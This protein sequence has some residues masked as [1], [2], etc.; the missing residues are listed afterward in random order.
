MKTF[1]KITL[2]AALAFISVSCADLEMP[3]DGRASYKDI[4]GHY[5]RTVIYANS[6]M[7]YV[8]QPGLSIDSSPLASLCDEAQD[9]ADYADGNI[10]N[11]YNG[12]TSPLYNPAGDCWSHYYA[13]IRRCNNFLL[14]I[15]DPEYC[16]PDFRE[17]EKLGWIAMVRVARAYYYLQL[18]K[19][20]GPV[21]L[22]TIPY[23]TGHDYT[24]DRRASFEEVADFIISEC[25]RALATP[26]P[27]GIFG[28]R[29][30]INDSD[31]GKLTR[32]FAYAIMS[33]TALFAASPLFNNGGASKYTWE[34]ATSIT[35]E[36]LD[37]CLNH[38]YELYTSKPSSSVAFGPYDYYCFTQSDPSRSVDKETIYESTAR[39]QVWM[40]CGLP[41]T[42]GM[43]KAGAC[44]S[45][46]LVD[47][48][49]TTDGQPVLDLEQPYLDDDHLKPNYN[50]DNTVY[51][52]ADPYANRDPRFYGSIY[53]NNAPR[54]LD[55]KTDVV[56]TYAGG[57][58]GISSDVNE[59]RYTRTGYYMRKFNNSRSGI[60]IE[61]DG[62]IAVYR[63][64]E[65][66]LNFA[67]AANHSAGPDVLV[68]SSVK[69]Q[70]LSARG[71]IDLI[72]ARV[73]MPALPKGLT[74]EQF[75]L[76]CRNERRVELA[77]EEKRFFDVRRWKILDRTDAFVTGMKIEPSYT[78]GY[79]YTRVKLMERKTSS[80]KYLL[81]PINQDD[82][83]KMQDYTGTAWQNPGW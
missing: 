28:F 78:G 12:M 8:Q 79:T 19:R 16:S 22:L 41:T 37:Q 52:P 57:N 27:D 49:E 45:Q 82:V 33:E 51:K 65:L 80:D 14:Y 81:F 67:E 62:F 32:G 4:F 61:G 59:R 50:R 18:I 74:K 47:C 13:G 21:P 23:S 70:A 17:E 20:Y 5:E 11:W 42:P 36:A 39:M 1:N 83:T 69:G 68:Q 56:E 25:Q 46:E 30:N 24:T 44:P 6:C 9:A 76:R 26:E 73:G 58:C 43:N 38:G 53:Y 34:L 64:A 71:A 40:Y 60:D 7:G 77:F 54:Y 48:Y 29:W 55:G 63:L 75:E 72:R 2:Y 35:K 31:R 15:N 3:A 66:Y 10:S